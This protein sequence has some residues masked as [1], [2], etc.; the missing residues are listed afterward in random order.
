MKILAFLVISC[1]MS[2][3]AFSS[4]TDTYDFKM[5]LQ[6]PRIYDN[7]ESLGSRKYQLQTIKGC[8]LMTYSSSSERPTISFTFLTNQT[9]KINGKKI[10]YSC[11]VDQHGELGPMTRVNLIGSNLT[12]KFNVPS[13][14]FWLDA[15]PDYSKGE[16]DEDNSLLVTLSGKGT[17]STVKEYE[18][19]E[20]G[21][22]R[23]RV[24]VDQW[25]KIRTISGNV[26]G[27]LGCGCSAYGHVSPTRVADDHGPSQVVD[28]VAAVYGTWNATWKSRTKDSD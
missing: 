14:C 19:V 22:V 3:A 20:V 4:V 18:W 27:T 13:V 23:K 21:N 12:G 7:T 6:V 17:T 25:Q 8:M 10:G 9:H 5:S 2:F 28:D 16:D 24:L 11:F 15:E 26:A 1:M